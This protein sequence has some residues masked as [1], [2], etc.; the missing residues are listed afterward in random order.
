MNDMLRNILEE[1]IKVKVETLG[2]VYDFL[3]KLNADKTGGFL[4]KFKLFLRE[5]LVE[6]IIYHTFEYLR[7]IS[8]GTEIIISET[9][10]QSTIAHAE[11]AFPGYIDSDFVNY[12]IDVKGKST[13]KTKVQVFE[14]IKD[15]TFTQIFGSFGENRDRLCLTQSQIIRFVKDHSKW[16]RTDGYGTF[17]FFKEKG[18]YFVADVRWSEGKLTVRVGCLPHDNVWFADD[19]RRLVVP[20]FC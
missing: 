1:L 6:K 14:Q 11:N 8:N 17:F 3:R 16:L 10:G 18:K 19:L 15:G 5:E 13:K 20:Q 9:D 7:L 12:G 2:L 4:R